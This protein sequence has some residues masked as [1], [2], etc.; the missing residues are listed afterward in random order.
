MA[1]L[2]GKYAC[3]KCDSSDAMAVYEEDEKL[4]GHCFSCGTHFPQLSEDLELVIPKREQNYE[5]KDIGSLPIHGFKSR[6]INQKIDELYGVRTSLSEEDGETVAERYYPFKEKGGGIIGWKK[7][8]VADKSFSIIREQQGVK[9]KPFGWDT[10]KGSRFLVITEGE[11]D[12]LAAK[13]MLLSLG[14]DYNVVSLNNGAGSVKT[15]VVD[16]YQDLNSFDTIVVAF[17]KD[18]QG[19]KAAKLFCSKMEEVGKAKIAEWKGDFKDANDFLL[20][21]K[22]RDFYYALLNAKE[23]HPGGIIK[24]SDAYEDLWK[25][26]NTQ[27]TPYPW[28]GLNNLLY[29]Q[30]YGELVTWTAG[31]GLG[32]T[33]VIRE[34]AHW[35]LKGTEDNLG[36]MMLEENTARTQWGLMAI[37]AN[38]PLHI[39]EE[40]ERF[41]FS[42]DELRGFWDKTVGTGRVFAYDHFGSTSEDNL[43][44]QAKYLIKGVGCREIFL[45][46]LSIVVSSM[47][48][49]GDERKTIDSIMTRLRQLAEETGAMIHLV[50]HL[51]RPA[52]DKGHER[53]SETSLSQLRGSHSIAQLSDAVIGLERDQQADNPKMANLTNVRVLKNRYSGLT[54]LACSLYYERETG[55]LREIQDLEEFLNEEDEDTTGPF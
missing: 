19:E 3:I 8:V 55:R 48:E 54:G 40:R 5:K 36:M 43:I 26:E 31:S 46:H 50:S 44:A 32:K 42:K 38:R 51:R 12:C 34:I 1:E 24:L 15:F 21:G 49:G 29:G 45:D 6:G 39:R 7:R 13:Q 25:N 22:A 10:V 41:G 47:E 17:D 16:N 27:S 4:H 20:A 28:E 52:G 35:N 2:L 23:H 11:E 33:A 9:A 18:Q 30:R 53:G 37:E 14:K